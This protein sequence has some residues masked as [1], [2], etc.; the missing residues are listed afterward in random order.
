MQLVQLPIIFVTYIFLIGLLPSTKA[1]LRNQLS[2]SHDDF[3]K[4]LP[5]YSDSLP[6][7]WYSGYLR[8]KINARTINTHYIYIESEKNEIDDFTPIIFWSNGGPG[9]SSLFGIFTEIGPLNL[10]DLSLQTKAF[11]RGG[12]P[13]PLYNSRGWAHLGG[14]LAFDAPAPVGFSYCDENMSGDGYSCG[15]WDDELAAKNNYLA[16]TAFYEK[17]PDLRTRPLF[18]TGESYAGIYIPMLAQKILEEEIDAGD[19]EKL[20]LI[21]FAV[22]D[23]CVGEK[24]VCGGQSGIKERLFQVLFY[25]GHGQIPWKTYQEVVSACGEMINLN[26]DQLREDDN[27]NNALNKVKEQV[28]G[29]YEYHLYDDCV[30]RNEFMRRQLQDEYYDVSMSEALNDYP[31]GGGFV[32]DQYLQLGTVKQALNIP[33]N[34]TFFDGDNGD[35]FNYTESELDLRPFYIDVA[36]GKYKTKNGGQLRM[37]VYNG[38]ADPA[39]TSFI[40]HDW[41][42]NL[43]LEEVEPWRPWTVDNCKRMGGHVTRYEGSFDFLTIR[44]AGHMV[45]TY[46]PDSA[47]AFMKAWVENTDYPRYEKDC[48][49]PFLK[50]FL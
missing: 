31:C 8:Y 27:C 46:K 26:M 40:A 6:S 4:S 47:F 28:G 43:G 17:F 15:G 42:S 5:G 9:A 30:Y 22:G 2:S 19:D 34:V 32:M 37:L 41:T 10:S 13:T 25:A 3:V 35:N 21:G 49:S 38:D 50:E 48:D 33:Q 1:N 20:N 29:V 7:P 36:K 11:K 45:P 23:A 16:L 44:G 24:S 18:L 39:I 12:I 14:I